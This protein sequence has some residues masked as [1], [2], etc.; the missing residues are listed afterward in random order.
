MTTSGPDRTY[1]LALDAV[2][3]SPSMVRLRF[4]SGV[5]ADG[6]SNLSP[7]AR[8][9]MQLAVAAEAARKDELNL[10]PF[11]TR[12]PLLARRAV[13]LC[14]A[15]EL[16]LSGNLARITYTDLP[17][18][19]LKS[20]EVIL[21]VVKYLAQRR[22]AEAIDL[23]N[24][25]ADKLP[26]PDPSW[27][28]CSA[29]VALRVGDYWNC[30]TRI[31]R[32]IEMMLELRSG[33]WSSGFWTTLDLIGFDDGNF[34]SIIAEQIADKALARF[35]TDAATAII[36][37]AIST[38]PSLSSLPSDAIERI[39]YAVELALLEKD[40]LPAVPASLFERG[41]S[42]VQ[43]MLSHLVKT[44]EK[45]MLVAAELAIA[46]DDAPRRSSPEQERWV[47]AAQRL[48]RVQKSHA[49]LSFSRGDTDKALSIW[50]SAAIL[51]A[52]VETRCSP[53]GV[54][55]TPALAGVY[56][57]ASVMDLFSMESASSLSTGESEPP[58]QNLMSRVDTDAIRSNHGGS[59]SYC[60][61]VER[62]S[63]I[64]GDREGSIFWY[65]KTSDRKLLA[66]GLNV[67][68]RFH[69]G[70][71][72]ERMVSLSPSGEALVSATS[73]ARVMTVPGISVLLGGVA[74]YYHWTLEY[75]PRILSLQRLLGPERFEDVR[76]LL[77]AGPTS[78]QLTMLQRA[79]VP[80]EALVQVP[81]GSE[82]ICPQLIVPSIPNADESI[83]YLRQVMDIAPRAPTGRRLYVSRLDVHP[84]RRRI[85][86]E[87]RLA[88]ALEMA[89]Y[90]IIVPTE[91][92]FDAQIEA[93]SQADVILGAHGAALT[94]LI[95][96]DPSA[97]VVEI[98]NSH[99]HHYDFFKEITDSLGIQHLRYRGHTE[100][101]TIDAE[102]AA[103]VIDPDQLISFIDARLQNSE[104]NS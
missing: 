65:V 63:V 95:Y 7:R 92:S 37:I 19:E 94:N 61:Q 8:E 73:P 15:R 86:D 83:A 34:N 33:L 41:L 31:G 68:P 96:A 72:R 24:S 79:G 14:G 53:K 35:P 60:V 45:G 48:A 55:T 56:E 64:Y 5:A 46:E 81:G 25:F 44:Y 49:Q 20:H 27:H 78:W 51:E 58:R 54:V 103:A 32:A 42:A 12:D 47:D 36:G 57:I 23:H 84:D 90:E 82:V 69:F 71:G 104:A 26:L 29:L 93:F 101:E 4:F 52:E 97:L 30:A 80:L 74:N 16:T 70:S 9:A 18:T 77:N 13:S 67:H 88:E 28:L 66:D 76:F 85:A 75:L 10:L 43:A 3:S 1:K 2:G 102:N 39:A 21:L 6:F 87:E 91:I 40:L 38:L 59:S 22:I 62:A 50:N 100:R 99:N 89:G 11:A 17:K 98:T